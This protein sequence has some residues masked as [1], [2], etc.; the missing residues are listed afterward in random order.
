MKVLY[1]TSFTLSHHGI[2]GQ[3]WGVRRFQNKDGTLTA[4]GK[5][6]YK[7][8]GEDVKSMSNEELRSRINRLRN[9]KTYMDL[10][11][12]ESKI[13]KAADNLQK[14]ASLGSKTVET[15]KN[16]TKIKGG[17]T[18]A[19]DVAGQ[20]IKAVTK[21]ASI[22]KKV[23]N[24]VT[25]SKHVKKSREKLDTMTD[26]EL[27]NIVTRL[28]LEKQYSDI[29]RET[30]NRGKVTVGKILDVAGDTLAIAAS[31]TGI[32]VGIKALMNK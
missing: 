9:E 14:K 13:S 4:K 8:S 25:D 11:K 27:K 15:K 21:S 26:D 20:G 7:D 2:K 17:N 3:R 30:R 23:D 12:N 19:Y 32:A 18:E 28:D 22:V 5:K 31:V 6:R 1:E 29:S 10:T 16:L 24:M